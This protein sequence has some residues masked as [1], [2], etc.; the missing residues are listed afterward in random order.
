MKIVQE[1]EL[2]S[3]YLV[4]NSMG[5]YISWELAVRKPEIVKKLVL[6]NSAGYEMD[7]VGGVFIQLSRTKLFKKLFSKG[8]PFPITK[9]AAINSLFIRPTNIEL[10]AFHEL[11]NRKETIRTLN[12]LGS[13]KQLADVSRIKLI[14]IPTLIIWGK[15][16]KVISVEHAYSFDQDIGNSSLKIYEDIGHVPMLECAEKFSNDLLA[17][18]VQ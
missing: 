11:L 16:D 14:N 1:L 10:E 4:G 3:V 12:K 17:F 2:D 18:L 5:G 13:S 15:E 9:R 8:I 7:K 6:V